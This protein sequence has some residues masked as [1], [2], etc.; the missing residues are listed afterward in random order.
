[1]HADSTVADSDSHARLSWFTCSLSKC[2]TKSVYHAGT[3]SHP[4][5]NGSLVNGCPDLDILCVLQNDGDCKRC[6]LVATVYSQ[7]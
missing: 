1:M 2:S 3:D 6:S 5:T 4:V 7:L